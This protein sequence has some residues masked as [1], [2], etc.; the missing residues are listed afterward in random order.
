MVSRAPYRMPYDGERVP[1]LVLEVNQRCNIR[2]T[3]CYKHKDGATKPVEQILAEADLALARRRLQVITL[4]GGEPTLHPELAEVVRALTARGVRVQMLTNGYDLSEE[5]LV[6]LR[7]AG[8]KELFLHID[9]LQTRPDVPAGASER[10]LNALRRSVAEKVVRSGIACSLSLTLYRAT[11]ADLPGLVRFTLTEPSI[12]RLLVTC[13]TDFDRI[14][15]DFTGGEILGTRQGTGGVKPLG[16]G[17][18]L[19]EQ[20]VTSAE[21]EALLRGALGME[22]F[23]YVASSHDL[24]ARRW[25]FYYSVALHRPGQPAELLHFDP[26]FQR[27]VKLS[28]GLARLRGRGYSFA[29]VYSSGQAALLGLLNAAAS[30]SPRTMART[31]R[32]LAGLRSDGAWL[33]HKSFTF[34]QGPNLNA[35]GEI[36]YCRD[37]PDATVRDGVMV[38]VC[39]V[40]VV[41]PQG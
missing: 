14:G 23:G 32:F 13:C 27:A 39:L 5:Q 30:L 41:K 11:L 8:L 19:A 12:T 21:V 6:R 20:I 35:D 18:S 15:R 2:C 24:E 29:Q 36:E 4:A 38:P 10:E 31:A 3:A 16:P 37:C 33:Q 22:P 26:T 34:Q 7:E 17:E 1:H 25:L 28:Y 40:D 9:S